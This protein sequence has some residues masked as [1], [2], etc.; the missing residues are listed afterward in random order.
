MLTFSKTIAR[1]KSHYGELEAPPAKG[2]FE[3]VLWENACYLLPD[4]RRLEVF[5]ALRHSVGL[6]AES[7]HHASDEV[8]LPLAKRGGMRPETRVFRWREIA[9]IT[10][11]QFSADL[12]SILKKPYAEA[13][14]A[15]KQFP[16][17]GDPGA[18]KILL[19]CGVA[20]G[21]PLESNGLRVLVRLGWGRLQKSYGATY[22]SVRDDLAPDLPSDPHSLKQAYLLLR[23]H[24]KSLCKDKAPLCHKCPL[25]KDCDYGTKAGVSEATAK[26]KRRAIRGLATTGTKLLI[27]REN[28]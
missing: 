8:L 2:P 14:R 4:E 26:L 7:I 10:L 1:L 24:G 5:E 25:A 28:P 13:T 20:F 15:L 27:R 3:L 11:T 16:N 6:N 12:N 18:E 22:R 19:F 21:L 9:R 23:E 17:I